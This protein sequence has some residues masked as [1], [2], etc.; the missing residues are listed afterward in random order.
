MYVTRRTYLL[1]EQLSELDRA[2][3][4]AEKDLSAL[5]AGRD[6]L[7]ERVNRRIV[8]IDAKNPITLDYFKDSP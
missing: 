3:R 1:L 8:G 4:A 6:A 2:T 5:R 7:L